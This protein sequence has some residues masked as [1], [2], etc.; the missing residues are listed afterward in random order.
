MPRSMTGYGKAE[1]KNER[2][3]ITVEIRN[4]N[5]RY[6]DIG[7]KLPRS[8]SAY[9]FMVK[10]LIKQKVRRGKSNMT[11]I[12]N[13]LTLTNGTYVIN[14]DSLKF[15]Y[16]LLEKIKKQTGLKGEIKLEHLLHFKELI[17]PEEI[18]REDKEIEQYLTQVVNLALDNLNEMRVKEATNISKDILNR[19]HIIE[20]VI[21][22]IFEKG[23][24]NPHREL[25][26]LYNRLAEKLNKHEIDR[27][28]L[29]LELA[30]IADR[31]DITEECTRMKSH[32]DLFEEI[33]QKKEE[34]GKQ[35]TFVLQEMQRESNT[36]GSKTTDVSIAHNVVKVKDEI[37]KLR[38]Q[39][40]NL[41]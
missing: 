5:N 10:E 28:R 29:E 38:E 31:V 6:L 12:F 2:Y 1:I 15:Y 40:Q 21:N 27:D 35:L 17:E 7:I 20:T 34:V 37:E 22:E 19:L 39:V 13:D 9:E 4:L 3:E 33:F 16:A 41:E 8:L 25:E 11:V 26:K 24:E 32:I 14:E 36:I 23:K 30:I 18:T